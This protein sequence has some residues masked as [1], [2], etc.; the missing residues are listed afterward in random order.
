MFIFPSVSTCAFLLSSSLSFLFT[1]SQT[2]FVLTAF[3]N[4]TVLFFVKLRLIKEINLAIVLLGCSCSK[5][6]SWELE[7]VSSHSNTYIRFLTLFL[8]NISVFS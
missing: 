6:Q 3:F 2:S 8:N 1:S 4:R 7:Q 5:L